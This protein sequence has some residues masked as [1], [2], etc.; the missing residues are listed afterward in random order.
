MQVVRDAT[1]T[2]A[3]EVHQKA[4]AG[5][6]VTPTPVDRPVVDKSFAAAVAAA[7]AYTVA[8][9]SGGSPG[10]SNASTAYDSAKSGTS[11][12]SLPDTPQAFS[13]GTG[14]TFMHGNHS[15][16]A[17]R[18]R[19]PSPSSC[20]QPSASSRQ[21]T[22]AEEYREAPSSAGKQ[23]SLAQRLG[24]MQLSSGMSDHA[25]AGSSPWSQ[26][27][28][29]PNTA[30][31]GLLSGSPLERSDHM[32]QEAPGAASSVES[33]S[34]L[35]CS[36]PSSRGVPG[37]AVTP[38]SAVSVSSRFK[39]PDPPSSRMSTRQAKTP[40]LCSPPHALQHTIGSKEL[41]QGNDSQGS[42]FQ[43]GGLRPA[44]DKG[45][46]SG[47]LADLP[48][49]AQRAAR[50]HTALIRHTASIQLAAE[51][52]SLLRLLALPPATQHDAATGSNLLLPSAEAAAEYAC[53]VLSAIGMLT[54]IPA[55]L[56]YYWKTLAEDRIA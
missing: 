1:F 43:T 47:R 3:S 6:K 54:T 45:N 7:R 14:N 15:K 19:Q 31:A 2:A 5:R 50:L 16:S 18:S 46:G 41:W 56:L 26:H 44:V 4:K 30:K 21:G 22:L 36:P 51:L 42:E 29:A 28:P 25:T 23:A 11:W 37:R 12:P 8:S 35:G 17:S 24:G 38:E 49:Q 34:L 33:N 10:H 9:A 27:V 20:A 53:C 48:H 55:S 40:L 13:E 52:E 32:Q 39:P